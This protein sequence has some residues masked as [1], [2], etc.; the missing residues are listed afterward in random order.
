MLLQEISVSV[1]K[2][3]LSESMI[4]RGRKERC[5]G[6][7]VIS[8]VV[9]AV[10]IFRVNRWCDGACCYFWFS[11]LDFLGSIDALKMEFLVHLGDMDG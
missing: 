10:E 3:S 9:V 11:E 5:G 7:V 4:V 2:S 1:A 8:V 6:A